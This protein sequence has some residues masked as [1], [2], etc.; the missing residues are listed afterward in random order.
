M[1]LLRCKCGKIVC[2][3]KANIIVIKCRHCKRYINIDTKEILQID[4]NA[5]KEIEVIL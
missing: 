2:E 1:E 3:L 4:Y 5:E